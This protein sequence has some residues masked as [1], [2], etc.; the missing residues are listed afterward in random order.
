MT[1]NRVER[2]LAAILAADIAGH[3]LDGQE[4]LRRGDALGEA[5]DLLVA[6]GGTGGVCS[7]DRQSY[8]WMLLMR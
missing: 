4:L 5:C 2:R 1:D 7:S 6:Q 3:T 8:R